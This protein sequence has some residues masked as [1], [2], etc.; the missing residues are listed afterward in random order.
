MSH[1]IGLYTFFE[2]NQHLKKYI[3]ISVWFYYTEILIF[4][5]L[6]LLGPNHQLLDRLY[7]VEHYLFIKMTGII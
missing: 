2:K 1:I 6:W 5:I 7:E 3:V 4:L